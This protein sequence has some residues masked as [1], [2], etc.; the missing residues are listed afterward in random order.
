MNILNPKDHHSIIISWIQPYKGF[1]ATQ[2]MLKIS[3]NCLLLRIKMIFFVLVL[4]LQAFHHKLSHMYNSDQRL[5]LWNYSVDQHSTQNCINCINCIIISL[6][7]EFGGAA[8]FIW[9]GLYIC[10][11]TV[12]VVG[13]CITS[14]SFTL[15]NVIVNF[16]YIKNQL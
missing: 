9:K 13:C 4:I 10:I 7:Q 11:S 3:I 6:H 12:P 1:L 2:G 15:L 8:R 16:Y 5:N 14:H